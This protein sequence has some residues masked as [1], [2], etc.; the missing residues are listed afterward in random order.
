MVLQIARS[1]RWLLGGMM[2]L[3]LSI[4]SFAQFRASI[5]GTVTD[6]T[7][8]IVVGATIT[9]SN[10]AT[11]QTFTTKTNESGFYRFNGL[12]PGAYK[13]TVTQT[14][15][16]KKVIDNYSI[17]AETAE[18]LDIKLDAGDVSAEVTVDAGDTPTLNTEGGNIGKGIT[19]KEILTLPQSGRDPY[20]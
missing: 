17:N 3:G 16:K 1:F 4:I 12:A 20:Q 14:N 2:I 9:L 11:N 13:I 6:S 8:A 18:G 5:Q 19:E 10:P 7:E 15:F